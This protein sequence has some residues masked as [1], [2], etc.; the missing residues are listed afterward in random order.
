M[1]NEQEAKRFNRG[2]AN[3]KKK[4][5]KKVKKQ[6]DDDIASVVQSQQP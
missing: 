1:G 3:L 2:V 5:S 6:N 4:L